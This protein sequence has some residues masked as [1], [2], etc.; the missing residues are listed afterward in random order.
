MFVDYKSLEPFTVDQNEIQNNS[1]L[2]NNNNYPL[3][4][5][6]FQYCTSFPSILVSY[7]A[8]N[9]NGKNLF[10]TAVQV[11][12]P[13]SKLGIN[14]FISEYPT[15]ISAL[16]HAITSR[17]IPLGLYLT[18]NNTK[19]VN[20]SQQTEKT[21][22]STD[23][24]TKLSIIPIGI[25]GGPL[26]Q[27][28][29][30][31]KLTPKFSK[32]TGVI[33]TTDLLTSYLKSLKG[34]LD[35]YIDLNQNSVLASISNPFPRIK[36]AFEIDPNFKIFTH[37]NEKGFKAIISNDGQG[38]KIVDQNNES[39]EIVSS[40]EIAEK[41]IKYLINHRKTGGTIITSAN[42][43]NIFSLATYGISYLNV[44][45][46]HLLDLCCKASYI[47]LLLGYNENG[48]FIHQGFGSFGDAFLSLAYLLEAKYTKN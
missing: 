27:T 6:L 4:L 44:K 33:G 38:L 46:D 5:A 32:K 11:V 26:S 16:S 2:E 22:Q 14:V 29:L 43:N 8:E 1:W 3:K 36:E 9:Y 30:N 15:P 28:N 31:Y 19:N 25:N 17:S 37:L 41:I 20:F 35:P 13:I 18:T 45:T 39:K 23:Q 21:D 48:V 12:Y 40:S 10:D 34:L 7:S 47:D 24:N 42:Y